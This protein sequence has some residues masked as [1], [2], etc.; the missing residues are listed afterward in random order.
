MPMPDPVLIRFL[1]E[2]KDLLPS[3]VLLRRR[4]HENPE[5]GLDLPL[6]DP[7]GARRVAGPRCR[8]RAWDIDIWSHRVTDWH[9]ARL[10]KRPDD[11]VARR[12]GR[13]GDAGRNG[14]RVCQQN[15]RTHARL[16]P[17]FAH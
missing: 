10:A 12:H 9:Q 13:V 5:L 11:P 16:R 7:S 3:A 8:Y 6:N 2:A 1:D 15:P 17:W 4:I 14:A